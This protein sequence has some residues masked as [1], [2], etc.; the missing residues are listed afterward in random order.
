MSL[1]QSEAINRKGEYGFMIG[2]TNYTGDLSPGFRFSSMR[3][4]GSVFYRHNYSNEVSILRVNLLFGQLTA[5][6]EDFD[7][8]LQQNRRLEFNT[9]VIEISALYEYDFFNYRDIKEIY[10][11]SPYLFGGLGLAMTFG[12]K[13]YLAIPFGAG[14]KLKIAPQLNLGVEFG[15]RKLFSDKLDSYNDDAGLFSSYNNDWYYFTG[16]TLSRTVYKPVCPDG[17]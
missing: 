4:A 6:E 17:Q 9:E 16:I 15:A 12:G 11:M 1:A 13:T 8:P 10:F 3:P 14:I 5:D 7:F 2:G